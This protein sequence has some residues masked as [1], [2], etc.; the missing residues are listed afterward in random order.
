MFKI[1]SEAN[2]FY[3]NHIVSLYNVDI[4]QKTSMLDLVFTFFDFEK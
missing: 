2:Y 1:K 3:Q 4:E